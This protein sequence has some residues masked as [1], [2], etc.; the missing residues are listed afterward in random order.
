MTNNPKTAANLTGTERK[1][2]TTV[3]EKVNLKKKYFD[4]DP[5]ILLKIANVALFILPKLAV[6]W[7]ILSILNIFITIYFIKKQYDQTFNINTKYHKKS[8]KIAYHLLFICLCVNLGVSFV[9]STI[10]WGQL[11]IYAISNMIGNCFS[12]ILYLNWS[13]L[14]YFNLN[15]QFVNL[16]YVL[17]NF[18]TVIYTIITFVVQ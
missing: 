8:L 12:F 1:K 13:R 16:F 6:F 14:H 3:E 15:I 9:L 7:I 18:I 5:R 17:V 4:E 10:S 11:K 2:V